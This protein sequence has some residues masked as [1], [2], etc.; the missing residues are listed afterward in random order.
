MWTL[1]PF[2]VTKLT[3]FTFHELVPSGIV[4]DCLF[5]HWGRP[6]VRLLMTVTICT[7]ICALPGNRCCCDVNS[8]L[9]SVG[10]MERRIASRISFGSWYP[11]RFWCRCSRFHQAR[12][13]SEKSSILVAFGGD[14]IWRLSKTSSSCQWVVHTSW[15]SPL[16]QTWFPF[17][18]RNHFSFSP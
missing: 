5:L 18:P 10:H 12:M 1:L 7:L 14:R 16:F 8:P 11:V 9:R 17:S 4:I 3:I 15:S 2:L 6:R 13:V